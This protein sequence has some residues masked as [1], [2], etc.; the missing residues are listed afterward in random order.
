MGV[1][2]EESKWPGSREMVESGDGIESWVGQ[3]VKERDLSR[4]KAGLG[5]V[6]GLDHKVRPVLVRGYGQ[7]H[8]QWTKSVEVREAPAPTLAP[9]HLTSF[10]PHTETGVGAVCPCGVHATPVPRGAGWLRRGGG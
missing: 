10:Y 7:G 9:T 8:G 3:L 4:D 6:C 2:V 1:Q 5:K